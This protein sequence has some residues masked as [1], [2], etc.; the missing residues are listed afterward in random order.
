[1]A[2][3]TSYTGMTGKVLA[4]QEG[5]T[6]GSF[7]AGDLVK[8]DSSGQ[9][10]LATAG[11]ILGIARRGYTGTQ[12]STIEVELIDPNE[13]Y[14]IAH[15]ASAT[16]QTMVGNEYDIDYTYGAQNVDTDNSSYDEI[17]VVGLHP[18]DAVT[19]SGGRLLVRFQLANLATR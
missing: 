17:Q 15:Q 2:S 4:F 13:I 5:G 10:V 11:K 19:T 18:G 7:A 9:V 8:T 1:M 6:P 14:V 3:V 16:A 12:A